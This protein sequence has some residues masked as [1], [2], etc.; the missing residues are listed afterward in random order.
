MERWAL[1]SGATSG[2]GWSTALALAQD[3]FSI[4][5]TGRRPERLADLKS[6]IE[7]S[8]Q[9]MIGAV[10]DVR[11]AAAV[12][13]LA[14][15]HARLPIEILV[16]NA[17]LARGVEKFQDAKL[18]DWDQM[19]DTNVKGLLAMTRAFLPKMLDRKKGH[20]INIGSVAGKWVYPGGAVYCATKFAVR[21]LS[22]GLRLD[23]L[24]SPIRV[25]NIEPGMVETEFS[26]VRFGDEDRA[27]SVYK[28]LKPLTAED[29]AECVVWSAR[30]PAHVNIQEMVIFPTAQA[31]VRDVW[32]E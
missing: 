20:V 2:I 19:F 18:E 16:N 11:D 10:L 4:L 29:I 5:A 30:R 26:K 7:S 25:T 32:R 6:K 17:G 13:A 1:V 27:K 15:E 21:A 12:Q 24:G 22:E 23:L 8:G 31:S 14:N 9:K 3:G 28:G